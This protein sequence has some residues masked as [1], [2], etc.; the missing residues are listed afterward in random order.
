MPFNMMDFFGIGTT[1]PQAERQR[2]AAQTLEAHGHDA[3]RI[4]VATDDGAMAST[5]IVTTADL[6]A[7]DMGEAAVSLL[8]TLARSAE[9]A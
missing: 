2:D 4:T 1:K 9:R 6:R 7:L 3:V 8:E 5:K